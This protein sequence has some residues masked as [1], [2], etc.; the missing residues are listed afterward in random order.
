MNAFSTVFSANRSHPITVNR[1]VAPSTPLP[2]RVAT[3]GTHG[4][5]SRGGGREGSLAPPVEVGDTNTYARNATFTPAPDW[6]W[7][8]GPRW[9]A[10]N[11]SVEA[12]NRVPGPG[13]TVSITVAMARP[14]STG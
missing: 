7:P 2:G 11:G 10:H 9:S 4:D 14:D 8:S 12:A 6:A 13:A 5:A 3:A 1:H